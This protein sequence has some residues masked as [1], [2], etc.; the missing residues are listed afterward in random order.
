[1]PFPSAPSL[2]PALGLSPALYLLGYGTGVAAFAWLARRRGL[3]T[4][5]IWSVAVVGLVGGLLG[6]NIA[7]FVG[8]GGKELGKSVLGG[9]VGGYLSVHLYKAVIGLR[10]PLGDLFAFALS[11]GEAVGRFGCFY[12]GC[13]FGRDAGVALW[14]TV[15][16]HGANRYPTQAFMSLSSAAIFLVL[17][18]LEK[19]RV[20]PEN[21]LFFV[22]GLLACAARFG[23]EFYRTASPVAI[24]LT[25][26]QW[27]CL[28]GA[29][30]FAAMLMRMTSKM[31]QTQTA[32]PA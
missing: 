9:I 26:A 1:M 19:R 28:A 31:R 30:F 14:W 4:T 24:G 22:Q 32:V 17:V 6:A 13:C 29:V 8:S 7:Q 25:A 10:R 27:V 2:L 3:S 15:H 18:V 21:G 12:G 20:L 5:G 11:A 23:I 16:Q